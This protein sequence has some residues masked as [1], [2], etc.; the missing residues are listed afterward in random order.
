MTSQFRCAKHSASC[1]AVCRTCWKVQALSFCL[2]L[3]CLSDVLE[4][5][6]F[7][8]LPRASLF[9]GRVGRF[10][11]YCCL[12]GKLFCYV[13][14]KFRRCNLSKPE[15]SVCHFWTLYINQ[16][17]FCFE[18]FAMFDRT[19]PLIVIANQISQVVLLGHCANRPVAVAK[20]I[21]QIVLLGGHCANRPVAVAKQI[22]QVVLL[23]GHCANQ[24]VAVAVM[25][26]G[27]HCVVV[28]KETN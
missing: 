5:S 14:K 10:K 26:L 11:L 12:V 28:S 16:N 6:S 18:R 4:G 22:N 8:I 3:C 25:P 1:F 23:G 17:V 9:V 15:E 7:I 2:V 19:D 20:Q 24:P 21:N 13:V 27:G